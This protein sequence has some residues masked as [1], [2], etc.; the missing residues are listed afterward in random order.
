[1]KHA[2]SGMTV[3]CQAN[4]NME[5]DFI[6]RIEKCYEN[7]A[8][9]TILDYDPRDKFNVQDLVGRTVIAFKRMKQSNRDRLESDFDQP[10]QRDVG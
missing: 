3:L 9:V 2:K 4:G 7:S 1:M 5:Y 6:G 8:L 10:M